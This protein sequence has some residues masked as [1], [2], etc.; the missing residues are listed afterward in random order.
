M[1]RAF[2]GIFSTKLNKVLK[3]ASYLNDGLATN[4]AGA[5]LN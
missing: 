4:S 1:T 3:D 5:Q 2:T